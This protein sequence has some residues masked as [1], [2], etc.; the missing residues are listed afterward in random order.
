[1]I[2][3]LTGDIAPPLEIGAVHERYPPSTEHEELGPQQDVAPPQ[4]A[5]Y[6]IMNITSLE[7]IFENPDML[8]WVSMTSRIE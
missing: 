2:A 5:D 7:T 1:M 8:N 6:D 4:D 3:K